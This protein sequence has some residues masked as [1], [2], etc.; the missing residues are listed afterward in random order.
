MVCCGYSGYNV[1]PLAKVDLFLKLPLSK[2]AGLTSRQM[3]RIKSFSS[4]TGRLIQR[5][6]TVCPAILSIAEGEECAS[7]LS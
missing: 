1:P 6:R 7:T 5:Y 2:D 4:K 3:I